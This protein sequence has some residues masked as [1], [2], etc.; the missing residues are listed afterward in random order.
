MS[1]VIEQQEQAFFNDCETG[2]TSAL[3]AQR[4]VDGALSAPRGGNVSGYLTLGQS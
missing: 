2:N 1:Q 4:A 3:F